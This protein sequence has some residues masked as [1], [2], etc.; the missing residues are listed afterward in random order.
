[1]PPWAIASCNWAAKDLRDCAGKSSTIDCDKKISLLKNV[2]SLP[3]FQELIELTVDSFSDEIARD[4]AQS[5]TA[6][7]TGADVNR[8]A[9]TYSQ[10]PEAYRLYLLGRFYW[11][12]FTA[13][14]LKKSIEC[15]EIFKKI[16]LKE[17]I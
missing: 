9:K 4:V 3:R 11:N 14:D 2:P 8:L 12:K 6:R 7:L 16:N 17:I 15:F 10:N 1:M 5:L 13:A